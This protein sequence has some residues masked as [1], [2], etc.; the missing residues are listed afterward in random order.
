MGI[1]AN[2]IKLSVVGAGPGSEIWNTS[3]WFGAVSLGSAADLLALATTAAPR[4]TTW[5]TS[6]KP[7]IYT[8]YLLKELRAYFYDGTSDTAK[9]NALVD[10][11]SVPGTLSAT[12]SPLDT[13]CVVS[14]LTGFSGRSNRGRVY[15]P[16]HEV[17][18]NTNGLFANVT[19]DYANATATLLTNISADWG[20]WQPKVVSRLLGTSEDVV[21]C[22]ADQRPDVQRRRENRLAVG[23]ISSAA[24]S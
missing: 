22:R 23:I 19:S 6:I 1:P 11:G 14:L 5:W 8:S 13:C 16:R 2:H 7:K 4:F 18:L 10:L 12:S 21:S 20:T 3:F 17:C 24:V 15:I 9:F